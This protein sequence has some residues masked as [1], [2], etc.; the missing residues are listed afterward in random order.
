[1]CGA[2][3]TQDICRSNPQE[4]VQARLIDITLASCGYSANKQHCKGGQKWLLKK[5]AKNIAAMSAAMK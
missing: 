1:M 2:D 5:L 4:V 3:C